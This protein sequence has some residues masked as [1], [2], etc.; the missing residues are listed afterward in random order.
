MREGNEPTPVSGHATFVHRSLKHDTAS[1]R[2]LKICPKLSYDG[3]I[4][5][6]IIHTAITDTPYAC[7]SYSWG[8][9]LALNDVLIND[10]LYRAGDNLFEFLDV[11][12]KSGSISDYI[13]IDAMCIAQENV[14]ERNHQ[15][16]QIGEIFS[17]AQLVC[18]WLGKVPAMTPIVSSLKRW[19]SPS[20][21]DFGSARSELLPIH[22]YRNEY[23]ERAW[24]TQEFALARSI[25]LV[26]SED[27]VDLA[28]LVKGMRTYYLSADDAYKTSSFHRQICVDSLRTVQK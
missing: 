25:V 9:R 17:S 3:L 8:E 2:L 28:V 4:R 23:W 16:T 12:R 24:I 22:L 11:F 27:L 13:W 7:L 1:I 20:F 21:E 6:E 26:L 10:D 19:E 14:R 18:I 5:C 15:V